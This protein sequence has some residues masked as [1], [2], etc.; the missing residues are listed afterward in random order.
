MIDLFFFVNVEYHV[1]VKMVY[2]V[3]LMVLGNIRSR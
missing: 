2:D 3:A 1:F